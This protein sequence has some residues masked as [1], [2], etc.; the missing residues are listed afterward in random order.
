M[1]R[2]LEGLRAR[3]ILRSER[4]YRA[5]ERVPRE[6]FV[7]EGLRARAYE[8]R[9]LPIG[10]GQTISAPHMVAIMTEAL[11]PP[12]CGL[13]LEVGAGSGYQAAVLAELV[14]RGGS[15]CGHVVSFE[16]VP[17]LAEHALR[18]LKRSGHSG[19][20][21]VVAGDGGSGTGAGREVFDGILVTAAAPRIP[22]PLLA[23]LKRGGRLVIPLGSP[24]I[25][26]LTIVVKTAEGRIVKLEDTPCVFVPMRGA[27]GFGAVDSPI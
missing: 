13:V 22:D 6:L 19:S 4:V 18:N 3:G 24:E 27:Y 14:D 9:P 8:D 2:L 1:E 5:M 12:E 20:V 15:G 10:H 7:P 25:Q 21:S 16:I 11:D 17:Q 23:E 26:I